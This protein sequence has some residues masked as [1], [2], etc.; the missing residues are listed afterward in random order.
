MAAFHL[1]EL[2]SKLATLIREFRPQVVLTHPYEG[3]HPDHDACALAVACADQAQR[4]GPILP[5]IVEAA[6]YHAGA[7][8]IETGCFLRSGAGSCCTHEV[9]RRLSP[10]E[11]ARR[12]A[13]LDCF[14]TQRETLQYFRGDIERYRI[15]PAYDFSRPP[16][17]G[18]L[19]YERHPWG[20]T[21]VKFCELARRA[22]QNCEA[23]CA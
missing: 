1:E 12:R 6:F 14:P 13:L 7:N 11:N 21:G 23:L 9:I 15:A 2:S 16:H 22:L 20:M 4:K 3:G 10:E 5:V 8:G 18:T 17:S 19:F